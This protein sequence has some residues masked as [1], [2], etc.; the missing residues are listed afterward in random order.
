MVLDGARVSLTCGSAGSAS[1]PCRSRTTRAC[2]TCRPR[3]A[4]CER[5]VR[6]RRRPGGHRRRSRRHAP[7]ADRRADRDRRLDHLAARHRPVPALATASSTGTRAPRTSPPPP[8]CRP[9]SSATPP[10]RLTAGG[11]VT[12]ALASGRHRRGHHRLRGHAPAAC[13]AP[14]PA[15]STASSPRSAACSRP[16]TRP[17][18][19]SRRTALIESVKRV[20][21][22]AERNTAVAARVHATACSPWTRAPATRRRRRSRSRPTI[23]GED[24]TTGFN[25]QFLLDGLTAIEQQVV[26]LAFTQASKPVVISGPVADGGDGPRRSATC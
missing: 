13:G 18:R 17:R 21:L 20:S 4:R 1:R 11:E 5:G 23:T 12:I 7:G 9:G 19:W 15:C 24:I 6:A 14:P 10:S 16:S 26:E 25:P 22:V 2:P 3:P 8:W